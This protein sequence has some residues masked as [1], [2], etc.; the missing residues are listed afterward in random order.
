MNER[1]KLNIPWMESNGMIVHQ[2]AEGI[3]WIDNFLTSEVQKE[4]VVFGEAVS[5]S[6]WKVAY[7]KHLE[8]VAETLYGSTD[9]VHLIAT[10]QI[11]DFDEFFNH[12]DR[13]HDNGATLHGF[14]YQDWLNERWSKIFTIVN[15]EDIPKIE[16]DKAS[17]I[18]R[19][20]NGWGTPEHVDNDESGMLL[21]ATI[22]Y[23]NDNFTGGELCFP[24]K[25]IVIQPKAGALCV[26]DASYNYRHEVK[27]VT[28]GVR[29]SMPMFVWDITIAGDYRKLHK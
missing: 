18:E 16:I 29:Y 5:D 19:R 24:E 27:P 28:E 23:G 25:D 7:T 26:F 2:Y 11:T 9:I 20:H 10:K 15:E 13:L 17:I 14:K 6:E 22:L 12:Y 21:Y 1:V 8:S 3:W 4:Y